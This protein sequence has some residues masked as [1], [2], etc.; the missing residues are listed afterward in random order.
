VVVVVVVSFESLS[1]SLSLVDLFDDDDDESVVK[2]KHKT[3]FNCLEYNS[4]FPIG[5]NGTHALNVT[6]FERRAKSDI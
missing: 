4:F 3:I 6:L 2:T 1:L 5:N